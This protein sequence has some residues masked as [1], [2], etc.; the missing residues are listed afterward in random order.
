M[1][2]ELEEDDNIL[3]MIQGRLKWPNGRKKSRQSGIAFRMN[4]IYFVVEK[5]GKFAGEP[6][7][8]C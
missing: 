4:H 5:R 3:L 1:E 2:E 6:S 8:G 7:K